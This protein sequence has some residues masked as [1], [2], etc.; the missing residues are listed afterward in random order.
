[1]YEPK[2]IQICVNN[3]AVY[4][5]LFHGKN[6]FE[7]SRKEQRTINLSAKIYFKIQEEDQITINEFTK[8]SS[9]CE[10]SKILKKIK[11]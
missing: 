9:S 7:L 4:P 10:N 6:N 5:Y 11:Y 3:R 2:K 1:M 8:R